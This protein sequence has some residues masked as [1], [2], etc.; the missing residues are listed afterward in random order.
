[1]NVYW[2]S[3]ELKHNQV[4]GGRGQDLVARLSD[5]DHIFDSHSAIIWYVDAWFD[6]NDHP[7][8]KLLGLPLGQT[9]RLMDF[10]S[11]S[12]AS[13]VGKVSV[14]SSFFQH[15]AP[16]TVHFTGFNA[17][18]HSFNRG[19]LGFPYRLVHSAVRLGNWPSMHG[20]GHVRTVSGEYN[21]VIQDY[22]P[23]SGN[24]RR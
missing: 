16:R 14:I 11:H 1:M 10:N 13:R 12:V 4:L 17:R 23:A 7:R 3:L 21:T 8:R 9:R 2:L 18:P 22:E 6:R 20:T 19:K 5:Q 24:G 15:L